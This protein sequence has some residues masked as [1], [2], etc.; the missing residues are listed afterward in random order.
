MNLSL[1]H[2]LQQHGKAQFSFQSSAGKAVPGYKQV[3]SLALSLKACEVLVFL[4][5]I[6]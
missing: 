6:V 1:Y 4:V 2:Y 5:N 3:R